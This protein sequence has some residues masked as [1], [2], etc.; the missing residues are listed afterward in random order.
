V[1][2]SLSPDGR[3]IVYS[4]P[5]VGN[6]S[7]WDIHAVDTQT[8]QEITLMKGAAS[9]R[10][11]M[12]TPDG[13]RL[14]FL[15]DRSG[16]D[17]VW[18]AAFKDGRITGEPVL[19]KADAGDYKPV[20]L[21]RSGALFYVLSHQST[22]VYQASVD[23]LTLRVQGVPAR[24]ERYL[25][26]NTSPSW[27]PAGDKFAYYSD[28]DLSKISRLIVRHA[29]GQET[30]VA[31][32]VNEPQYPPLW[33]SGGDRLLSLST[34]HGRIIRF[35]DARTGEAPQPDHH[36]GSLKTMPQPPPIWYQWTT[37]PDCESI[38]LSTWIRAEQRRRIYRYDI[39]TGKETEIYSDAGQW[40]VVP[41]VSPDGRW[42]ALHGELE[43]GKDSGLMVVP[44]AGGTLRMLDPEGS[45]EP[46]WSPDS[47]HLLYTRRVKHAGGPGTENEMYRVPVEGGTPQSMGLRMAG[48]SAPSLNADNKRILFSATETSNELW[49]LRNLPIH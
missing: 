13:A 21:S 26:H 20:R 40:A 14:V 36:I 10:H 8:G 27:S 18:M 3:W 31:Q 44:T 42:L 28:R 5:L 39:A 1:P 22:D 34:P 19:I 35:F 33:C 11:P 41:R 6:T 4:K 23:P 37:S 7:D 2:V 47:K 25:G 9:D 38:Y 46:T 16:K 29:D 30:V 24:L 12:W 49:V 17:G 32:P 15:S 45:V 48:A 43:G